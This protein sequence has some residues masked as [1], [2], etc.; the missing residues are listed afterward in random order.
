MNNEVLEA[1]QMRRSIRSFKPDRYRKRTCG[2]SSKP[3]FMQPA[4]GAVRIP[5]SW[6][7]PIRPW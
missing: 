7:L 2:K 3:A 5:S 1:M 4:D 6:P